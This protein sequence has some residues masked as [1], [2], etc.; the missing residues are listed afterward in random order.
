MSQNLPRQM[1]RELFAGIDLISPSYFGDVRENP[2]I[3]P[4][5]IYGAL[6]LAIGN[7]I[8]YRM[9]NFRF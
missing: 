1:Q 7:F 2:I 9:V 4:A 6:S 8:M 3:G 5:L